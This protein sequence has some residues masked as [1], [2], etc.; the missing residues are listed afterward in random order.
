[1]RPFLGD[2]AIRNNGD[3]VRTPDCGE[4][5]CDDDGGATLGEEELVQS[6]LHHAL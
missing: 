5:V 6:S 1:M 4:T 3:L 2:N